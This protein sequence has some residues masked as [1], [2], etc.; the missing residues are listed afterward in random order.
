MCW[1]QQCLDHRLPK[2]KSG[3]ARFLSL[4]RFVDGADSSSI[5]TVLGRA[6]RETSPNRKPSKSNLKKQAK[7]TTRLSRQAT[8]LL[9]L[10][11]AGGSNEAEKSPV[12][13][14]ACCE[15]LALYGGQF[16]A[17]VIG[18]LWRAVLAGA[19]TQSESFVEAAA[20]EDWQDV[21]SKGQ[22]V[23]ELWL[24]AGLLP[25]VCGLLF[26]DV[27]GAPKVA[28]TGR[29]TLSD[30]FLHVVDRDGAPVGEV[31]D[32]L[33]DFLA[34]WTDGLLVSRMFD[35]SL[36]KTSAA[37]R[38]D[39]MLRRLAAAVRSAE[40]VTCTSSG[41]LALLNLRIAAELTG[42]AAGSDTSG[43]IGLSDA[44]SGKKP[45]DAQSK[46]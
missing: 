7:E 37:K 38:F 14:L 13:L 32:T 25:L 39:R 44:G 41:E 16:P 23:T 19:L 9:R 46:S 22:T 15:L 3:D 21:L 6:R 35:E 18:G 2:L 27:K 29:S 34:L 30:Q 20:T 24:K 45:P 5:L 26:D 8:E 31:F 17:E 10:W 1:K 40:A 42:S 12:A 43:A 11:L 28:R 4:D 36:W 33:P